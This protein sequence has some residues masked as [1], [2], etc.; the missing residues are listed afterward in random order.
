MAVTPA[1]ARAGRFS[2]R[3]ACAHVGGYPAHGLSIDVTAPISLMYA[4]VIPAV[5]L[6]KS[7]GEYDYA[8]PEQY[9]AHVRRGSWIVVPWRNKPTDA[10]VIGVADK[11]AID[12]GKVKEMIGFGD[13][14]LVGDDIISLLERASNYWFSSP[15]SI[16]KAFLPVTPKTKIIREPEDLSLIHI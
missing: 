5:R 11:P 1:F 9:R 16:V 8:V 12:P 2:L 7:F 15:T 3:P 13:T 6:P 4:K 10:L 14:G